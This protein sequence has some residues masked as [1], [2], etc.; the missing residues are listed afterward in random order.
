MKNY[1]TICRASWPQHRQ[2]AKARDIV[3]GAM[4][5]SAMNAMTAMQA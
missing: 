2:R 1:E 3:V 5:M 4:P